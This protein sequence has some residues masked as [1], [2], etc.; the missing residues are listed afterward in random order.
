MLLRTLSC[1]CLLSGVCLAAQAQEEK[2]AAIK[3]VT[4]FLKGA[5]LRSESKVKLPEG[6]SEIVFTNVAGNINEKSLNV[7]ADN[8]AVVQSAT[9]RNN[10]LKDNGPTP[11]AKQI[12]D[13]IIYL[14]DKRNLLQN[15]ITAIDEQINVIRN[16]RKV[17]TEEKGISTEEL[18]KLLSLVRTDMKNLLDEK[19]KTNDSIMK[20]NTRINLLANQL[21]EEN[22]RDD[23]PA[24]QITV[25]FYCKKATTSNIV[26]K[27]VVPTAGWIPS[28][29]LRVPHINAPVQLA[30][31]AH[32][33]Q[34]SGVDWNK[35]KLTLSAGNPSEGAQ[36]PKL[37]PWHLGFYRHTPVSYSQPVYNQQTSDYTNTAQAGAIIGNVLDN[38]G[39]P[40]I[41]SV[42]Q[43]IQGGI[44]KNGTVSDFDGNYILKPL[45]PGRYDLK[46][47][48]VGY[49]ENITTGV[50]VNSDKHTAVNIRL[51]PTDH[52]LEEVVV[53][54][55]KV[56][57]IDKYSTGTG[58]T[59]T[60]DEI[61]AMPTRNTRSVASTAPGVYDGLN[62]GGARGDGTMYIVDG[63]QVYGARGINPS[64]GSNAYDNTMG[65][66]VATE[67]RGV[68][69]TFDIELPYTIPGDGKQI[70]VA[71]KSAELLASYRYYAVP[72]M[73]KDAFLQ[74]QIT[75]WEELDLLPAQ[76]NIFYEGTYVGQGYIDVR[77]VKDTM[78]LS[79]G[80]DKKI[81]VTRD[82]DF[83]MRS[84]KTIGSNM[85]ESFVYKI[86]VRNTRSEDIELVLTDQIPV[87][88]YKSINVDDVEYQEAEYNKDSGELL[89][90]LNV[91]PY[92]TSTRTF[93][94]TVKYPKRSN[95]NL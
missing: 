36:A 34:N 75:G 29:D 65:N 2:K 91:E 37:N 50:I 41:N 6:E 17:S 46:T 7:G 95:I 30:Y 14:S 73:D 3:E 27:Y 13:S 11:R 89:W 49:K 64:Q 90:T 19:T 9:F 57:L 32:V 54:D 72:K 12:E 15:E 33:Y 70:N 69:T 82:R 31:K 24:G 56:P 86:N 85:K 1:L 23:D 62:I 68:N 52:R 81:V 8:G 83:T 93:G 80:R 39:E 77:N 78:N 60:S 66:Y 16:N 88:Y 25:K 18:K 55:Y 21:R 74:A 44:V 45:S 42:V 38:N 35:V 47:S 67:N 94:F 22:N 10:Y 76:T 61:D 79:L 51:Q 28:Y 4:V 53:R 43:A 92:K 48:Y 71:V 59:I 5:E 84:V 20:L 26:I 58:R 87:S 63:I 40:I